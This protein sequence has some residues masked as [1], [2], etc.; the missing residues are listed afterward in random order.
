MKEPLPQKSIILYAD[1]DLDDIELVGEAIQE[2][3]EVIELITFVNGQELINFLVNHKY[4]SF[5]CV[6]ILDINMPVK[7]GK[8]TLMELRNMKRFRD[9]PIILF[10]TSTLVSEKEFAT[11]FNADFI[12]KPIHHNAICELTSQ[13]KK[14]CN[15]NDVVNKNK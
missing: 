13:L 3:A 1:D 8:Q 9:L 11:S 10:S 7:N 12:G 2:Y 5:P 6:I 14:Y 15:I 4:P